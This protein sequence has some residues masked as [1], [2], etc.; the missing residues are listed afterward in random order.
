MPAPS[1]PAHVLHQQAR[2]EDRGVQAELA[3]SATI[4]QGHGHDAGRE[5]EQVC[6]PADKKPAWLQVPR[7]LQE[8]EQVASYDRPR[9]NQEVHRCRRERRNS[10]SLL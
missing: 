7:C 1:Q 2:A 10:R 6:F 5:Q 3:D 4:D 9:G 8:W